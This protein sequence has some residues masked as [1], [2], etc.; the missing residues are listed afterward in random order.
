ME[1][2]GW[3]GPGKATSSAFIY[4]LFSIISF[5]KEIY[6]NSIRINFKLK[7]I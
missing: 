2:P 1:R 4:F 7:Q 6:K 3:A 5:R